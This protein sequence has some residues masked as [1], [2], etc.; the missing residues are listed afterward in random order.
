MGFIVVNGAWIMCYCGTEPSR[1]T[2][3]PTSFAPPDL[4]LDKPTLDFSLTLPTAD[5]SLG[6]SFTIPQVQM[7]LVA[8]PEFGIFEEFHAN[9]NLA[10]Q[11]NFEFGLL[12]GPCL[13]F[14]MDGQIV[15]HLNFHLGVLGG[16]DLSLP[17][18]SLSA[19]FDVNLDVDIIGPFAA[20]NPIAT[21]HDNIPHVNIHPFGLCKSSGNP[22][23]KAAGKPVPCEPKTETPWILGSKIKCSRDG[24]S[25]SS[26]ILN[27]S[28]ILTCSYGCVI[29]VVEPGQTLVTI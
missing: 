11:A 26:R 1:L 27:D 13:V 9:G 19:D 29:T 24:L 3:L 28:S 21:I 14:D 17:K 7:S 2:V 12:E 5:F 18:M 16:L 25:G 22:A 8:F 20:S 10:I 15:A 4:S 23:V 6:L